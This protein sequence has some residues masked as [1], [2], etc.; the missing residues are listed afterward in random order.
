LISPSEPRWTPGTWLGKASPDR[1]DSGSFCLPCF[2][3][4]V[5]AKAMM[6]CNSVLASV[7]EVPSS[8]LTGGDGHALL[9]DGILVKQRGFNDW[10]VTLGLPGHWALP[11]CQGIGGIGYDIVSGGASAQG[12]FTGSWVALGMLGRETEG[13][14]ARLAPQSPH[15]PS[16][17]QS[18]KPPRVT[19]AQ[20]MPKCRFNE[21]NTTPKI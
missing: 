12:D 7:R 20:T 17:E 4:V 3:S 10:S 11:L 5:L 16:A 9:D 13:G 15:V 21:Y 18:C 2:A 14:C 6:L 8:R 19:R 1:F